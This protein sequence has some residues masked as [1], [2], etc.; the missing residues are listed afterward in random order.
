MPDVKIWMVKDTVRTSGEYALKELLQQVV[1]K[2]MSCL[3]YDRNSEE[4]E[5]YELSPREVD[6]TVYGEI[7][8]SD[9][10]IIIEVAAYDFE[11]RM[12]N[13]TERIAIIA[14]S[15]KAFLNFVPGEK[16]SITFI[17]VKQDHWASV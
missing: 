7:V 6:I 14:E 4:Y 13:I 9:A 15:I 3:V 10:T 5:F 11:D 8:R 2:Q 16:V 17:P 1:A 12:R